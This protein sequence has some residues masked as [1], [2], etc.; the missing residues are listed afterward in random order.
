MARVYVS[1]T[2]RDL[3]DYR[4][5]AYRALRQMGHDVIAMEDYAASHQRPVDKCLADVR[6]ADV[7][8]GIL[9]WR[10][11]Y[12]PEESNPSGLSIT[13]LEYQE[14]KKAGKPRLLFLLDES[15]PWHRMLMDSVTGDGEGGKRI[16]QL[17]RSAEQDMIVSYFTTA[18]QLATRVSVA[19]ADLLAHSGDSS[20]AK[21]INAVR[22]EVRHSLPSTIEYEVPV[23]EYASAEAILSGQEPIGLVDDLHAF[24]RERGAV[25]VH[26]PG[27]SGKSVLLRRLALQQLEQD[28]ACVL[29]DVS[30]LPSL[31]PASKHLA[32]LELPELLGYMLLCSRHPLTGSDLGRWPG[33][34]LLTVDGLNELSSETPL[35]SAQA[36]ILAALHAARAEYRGLVVVVADRLNP[37]P[38]ADRYGYARLALQP[39]AEGAVRAVVPDYEELPPRIKEILRLPFFLELWRGR[40]RGQQANMSKAAMLRQ[41][42]VQRGRLTDQQLSELAEIA[43]RAYET[44][45]QYFRIDSLE[46]IAGRL[47]RAGFLIQRAAD[48]ADTTDQATVARFSHELF[49]DY[50]ASAFV[51][52][53]KVPWTADTLDALSLQAQSVEAVQ[54]A[55][56]QVPGADRDDFL[57]Q[58]FDWNDTAAAICLADEQRHATEPGLT[59]KVRIAI[60]ASIAVRQFDIFPHTRARAART[61]RRLPPTLTEG[62][63]AQDQPVSDTSIRSLVGGVRSDRHWFLKWQEI[64]I[65]PGI[66]EANRQDLRATLT[67]NPLLGWC[68]ANTIRRLTIPESIRYQ[69]LGMLDAFEGQV[70]FRSRRFRLAHIMGRCRALEAQEE[71]LRL[72]TTDE[73]HWV[74]YGAARSLIELAWLSP[75]MR[76]EILSELATL[77]PE[78]PPLCTNELDRAIKI[79]SENAEWRKLCGPLQSALEQTRA[80]TF[81]TTDP[82]GTLS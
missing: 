57:T 67:E 47:R 75:S 66:G 81:G 25:L 65:Q 63:L 6:R 3:E 58:V 32:Q 71:L 17:R 64:F 26:G 68:A 5:A 60:L 22:S 70:Q 45:S 51:A 76:A 74:R 69:M 48:P 24:A 35:E 37:R 38:E 56:E 9:A 33:S 12:V 4:D 1:S 80:N 79:G 19:V 61:L 59:P 8:V 78:L 62:F 34:I 27:G 52:E 18:D 28:E 29:M 42:L 16:E 46:S 15:V 39:L 50:L 82:G 72:L 10:Y 73:Y 23:A 44:G 54:L 40:V 13:E 2:F 49:H 11:G 14:A 30:L 31:V 55:L 20:R 41:T 7:Y 53:R 43:Y 77:V 21:Y 36:R